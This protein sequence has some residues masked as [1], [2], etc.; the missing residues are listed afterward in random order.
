M[1]F[2]SSPTVQHTIDFN[3]VMAP[4]RKDY[5][6][7]A[8]AMSEEFGLYPLMKFNYHYIE[9][10]ITEFFSTVFFVNDDARTLKWMT[11][12][13][14]LECTLKE[15]GELLGYSDSGTS[16]PSG[17]RNHENELSSSKESI[18]HITMDGGTPGKTAHLVQ[19]FEILHRIYRETVMPRVGN[20]DE[21]HGYMFDLLKNSKEKQGDRKSTRL[22]SSHRSLSRM[23][24]S[25]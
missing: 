1:L 11:K 15:F 22:N 10:Y 13:R 6:A 4:K 21:V 19:P 7:E 8:M 12:D 20:W 24:S 16:E 3:W 23:P 2:R 9:Y 17:W 14:M 18:A 5:F 25:A